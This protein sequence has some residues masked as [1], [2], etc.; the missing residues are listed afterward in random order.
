MSRAPPTYWRDRLDRFR[1]D[2]SC[3]KELLAALC[4]EPSNP[5]GPDLWVKWSGN[6]CE[7]YVVQHPFPFAIRYTAISQEAG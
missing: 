5:L 2:G 7:R 3:E 1:N 6:G 4:P